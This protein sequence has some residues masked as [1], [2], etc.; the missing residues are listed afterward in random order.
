MAALAHRAARCARHRLGWAGGSRSASQRLLLAEAPKD[1]LF[2]Q[3]AAVVHPGG[4]GTTAAGLRAGVPTVLP[5]LWRSAVLGRRVE[6]LGV[7]PWP[8]PQRRLTVD[9]LSAA[10]RAAVGDPRMRECAAALGK[11]IRAEDG[12]GQTVAQ[13]RLTSV[14]S[15]RR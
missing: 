13:S 12:V 5:V 9:A 8:I 11:A 1:W 14:L 6:A 3:M 7:G 15:L 4:A 2:P 10:I